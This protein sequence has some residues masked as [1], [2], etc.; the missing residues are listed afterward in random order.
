MGPPHQKFLPSSQVVVI[1]LALLLR[2]ARADRHKHVAS[3]N[4]H[5]ILDCLNG[6]YCSFTKYT[7]YP[8]KGDVGFYQ[9]CSCRPGFGGG[10][11]EKAVEECQPPHYRCHNGAPCEINESG[12]LAC[13]CS[14][15]DSKSDLAGY[16][17]RKPALALC[18]TLDEDNKSYCTN[19][20]VCLSSMTASSK[21]L[22]FSHPN[23]HQGC[24]CDDVFEGGHCEFLKDM[25]ESSLSKAA[26]TNNR[27]KQA[28][29]IL[30]SLIAVAGTLL[31]IRRKRR[32][33]QA[34]LGQKDR[35]EDEL[36]N[37]Y[38]GEMAKNRMDDG[39][40]DDHG[41]KSEIESDCDKLGALE[42]EDGDLQL[43]LDRID[44]EAR[45]TTFETATFETEEPKFV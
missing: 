18:D 41:Q 32:R 31:V 35:G 36:H 12:V 10:S 19:G 20:G 43:V 38:R 29:I 24:Q 25:P 37:I 4:S 6:G 5:C 42:G 9:S 27:A 1:L 30:S 13:D 7:D 28:F 16:M 14:S 21:H 34:W 45:P 2:T 44:T 23:V 22:V 39:Y 17:C 8:L 26:Q 11:C 40:Y 3:A 33:H 15:A